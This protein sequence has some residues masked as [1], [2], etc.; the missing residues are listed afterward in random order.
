MLKRAVGNGNIIHIKQI[1]PVLKWII[2]LPR[3][4]QYD[5]LKEMIEL[6]LLKRLNRDEFELVSIRIKKAPIDYH[7][8]PLW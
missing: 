7:G 3:Q 6:G 1:H 8:E 4:Y 5:I 2:R